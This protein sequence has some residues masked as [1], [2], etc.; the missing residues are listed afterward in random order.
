MAI[1]FNKVY[2]SPSHC[3]VVHSWNKYGSVCVEKVMYEGAVFSYDF[4]VADKVYINLVSTL[5]DP[6]K[7]LWSGPAHEILT[8]EFSLGDLN[9]IAD[10]TGISVSQ[11]KEQVAKDI[12]K[13]IE[14]VISVKL[15]KIPCSKMK[16]II[17]EED[18]LVMEMTKN[19]SSRFLAAL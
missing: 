6:K 10:Q 11:Y 2:P 4:C 3:E 18:G 9:S 1:N 17:V 19:C 16:R 7:Y 14:N 15:N 8:K 13:E 5:F 12:I